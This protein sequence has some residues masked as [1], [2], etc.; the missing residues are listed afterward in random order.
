M[1]RT[2]TYIASRLAAYFILWFVAIVLMSLC[3]YRIHFTETVAFRNSFYDPIIVELLVSA[4]LAII[5]IPVTVVLIIDENADNTYRT[6]NVRAD[7]L[8]RRVLVELLGLFILWVMWLVGA[9]ITTNKII[10]GNNYCARFAFFTKECNTLTSILVF[11]WVGWSMLTITGV[12]CLM[13]LSSA[14][15]ASSMP[16]VE[17]KEKS[18]PPSQ[19]ATEAAGQA[20]TAAPAQPDSPN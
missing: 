18:G 7:R 4:I 8:P 5:W 13:H 11:A 1:A 10:P 6:H 3:A 17:V 15:T 14:A 12:L 2:Y 19:P 16:I 20:G 9:S